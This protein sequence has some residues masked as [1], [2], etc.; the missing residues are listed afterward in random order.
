M[1]TMTCSKS[2]CSQDSEI[3]HHIF[4]NLIQKIRKYI[5]QVKMQILSNSSLKLAIYAVQTIYIFLYW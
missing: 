5:K 1:V 3:T 4:K 2:L